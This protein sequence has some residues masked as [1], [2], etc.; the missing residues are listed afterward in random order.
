MYSGDICVM[1]MS[2]NLAIFKCHSVDS[3]QP[4][5]RWI[6]MIDREACVDSHGGDERSLKGDQLHSVGVQVTFGDLLRSLQELCP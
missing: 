2:S 3:L 6:E 4:S 1:I 5:K